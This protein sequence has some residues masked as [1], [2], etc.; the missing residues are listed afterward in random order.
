M[1]GFQSSLEDASQLILQLY[2][3]I[4]KQEE[5]NHWKVAALSASLCSLTLSLTLHL[6]IR[7]LLRQQ[8]I[9]TVNHGVKISYGVKMSWASLL[10][11][12]LR[13]SSELGVRVLCIALF[14]S[15]FH[16]FAFIALL[17]HVFLTYAWKVYQQ[18]HTSL[19]FVIESVVSYLCF[20]E[21][22]LDYGGK[23]HNLIMWNSI[24]YLEN[25]V[26]LVLWIRST[27]SWFEHWSFIT[28]CC[29]SLLHLT[30]QWIYYRYFHPKTSCFYRAP[31]P[32][33]DKYW[34]CEAICMVV[35][36]AGFGS[37]F[38]IM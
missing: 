21:S 4:Y 19:N 35:G 34:I 10:V 7:M 29:L 12:I 22:S 17:I 8:C 33:Q 25:Y 16:S 23:R 2:I 31:S 26:M 14:A 5:V 38:Y 11:D 1:A 9:Y 3:I 30:L 37:A 15:V 28:V 20:F 36:F 32:E 27:S 24:L 13:R 6:K 18:Y